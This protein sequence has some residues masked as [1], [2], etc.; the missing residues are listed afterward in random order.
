MPGHAALVGAC[1]RALP[2]RSVVD[3][4]A[5]RAPGLPASIAGAPFIS[6]QLNGEPPRNWR[7]GSV[8]VLPSLPE[9]QFDASNPAVT[10]TD[11]KSLCVHVTDPVAGG[12]KVS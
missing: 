11:W 7:A 8:V 1:T 2:A 9:T 12:A 4:P 5:G 3:W 6:C 10:V